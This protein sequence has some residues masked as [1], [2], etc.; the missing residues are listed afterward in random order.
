MKKI[1]KVVMLHY[2]TDEPELGSLVKLRDKLFLFEPDI[3]F[4][5]TL[6]QHLYFVSNEEIKEGDIIYSPSEGI[7]FPS[8]SKVLHI[9]RFNPE[10]WKKVVATNDKLLGLPLIPESF[11]EDYVKS[12]G[13]IK[14]V[15]LMW[16]NGPFTDYHTNEV[17]LVCVIEKQSVEEAAQEYAWSELTRAEYD[18]KELRDKQIE[19][20]KAGAN[21]QKKQDSN[22]KA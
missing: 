16:D 20:F 15:E 4:R 11:I 22:N 21:W 14:Q 7:R 10:K 17:Q 1:V 5:S 9:N 3:N 13:E 12:N 2:K 18:N 6:P 19:I 8:I